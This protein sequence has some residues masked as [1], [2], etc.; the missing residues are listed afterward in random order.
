M[1]NYVYGCY[2]CDGHGN[3]ITPTGKVLDCECKTKALIKY[4][5]D[6]AN[7]PERY[8]NK[9]TETPVPPFAENYIKN[10]SGRGVVLQG[11]P[12]SGK[13]HTAIQ[14]LHRLISLEKVKDGR[15]ITCDDY[16]NYCRDCKD[17]K[18]EIEGI[19]GVECLILDDYKYY[20]DWEQRHLSELVNR[21]YNKCKPI[22]LTTNLND[23]DLREKDDRM[24]GRL[25]E[26]CD[27]YIMQT[28][29]Y[30]LGGK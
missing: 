6:H 17:N 10:Y 23:N 5:I 30:R 28:R 24:Y 3:I 18:T 8:K 2:K 21:R 7:F 20:V 9:I 22:I 12:G 27:F 11:P 16:V 15:F 25:K 26:D 19:M 1:N 29:N 4:Q 13:T 14:I